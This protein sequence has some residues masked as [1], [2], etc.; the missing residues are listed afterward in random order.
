MDIIKH[1]DIFPAILG[2]VN[3]PLKSP[4]FFCQSLDIFVSNRFAFVTE[5]YVYFTV[6]C[7]CD[8]FKA[9]ING[10]NEVITSV[11]VG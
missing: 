1:S 6:R 11:F 5:P 2:R 10:D 7:C 8:Y 9:R 3:L 4:F